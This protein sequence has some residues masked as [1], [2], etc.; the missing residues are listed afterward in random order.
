MV[1]CLTIVNLLCN[2]IVFVL[3]PCLRMYY[4]NY[5]SNLLEAKGHRVIQVSLRF[6]VLI[7]LLLHNFLHPPGCMYWSW[8][9]R[10][11]L[12][13]SSM[14]HGNHWSSLCSYHLGS[15]I[16]PSAVSLL[17]FPLIIEFCVLPDNEYFSFH[18][19]LGNW[20]YC[21]GSI[22]VLIFVHVQLP[23]DHFPDWYVYF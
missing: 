4:T 3:V 11:Q 16:M 22:H 18:L 19:F 10:F 15:A 12:C 14:M 17:Y 9:T 7:G 6:L 23:L 8:R 2:E 1:R 20:M 21:R 13:Y 5:Q